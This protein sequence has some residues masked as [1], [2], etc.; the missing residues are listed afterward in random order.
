MTERIHWFQ[1]TE[2]SWN[3]LANPPFTE[4]ITA[5][6]I[7]FTFN[8]VDIDRLLNF[9]I[10][11][12]DF[13]D[14]SNPKKFVLKDPQ[15]WTTKADET[16]GLKVSLKKNR[17]ITGKVDNCRNNMIII[18][19]P[20]ELPNVDDGIIIEYG[21]SLDVLITVDVVQSDDDLRRISIEKRNC[22]FQEERVLKFF[23]IYTKTNCENECAS[24]VI[25]E[26]CGCIPFHRV[27]NQTM[28]VCDVPGME[29]SWKYDYL[30]YDI[31]KPFYDSH[32]ICNCLDMCNTITYN[33]DVISARYDGNFSAE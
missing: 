12:D 33:V 18:H 31:Y 32:G 21:R 13:K 26:N 7:G 4:T 8:M 1:E 23:K 10:T 25:Y 22:F 28:R 29:C 20:Y 30:D 9:S 2:S 15:P 6:G 27:R 11:S 14:S 5:N 16:N 24:M 19:S 3:S 17:F